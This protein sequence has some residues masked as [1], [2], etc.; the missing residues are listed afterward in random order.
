MEILTTHDPHGSLLAKKYV[1]G[2]KRPPGLGACAEWPAAT[3]E[4]GVFFFWSG[5]DSAFLSLSGDAWPGLSG[6]SIRRETKQTVPLSSYS[7]FPASTTH[8]RSARRF[9]PRPLLPVSLGSAAA[10]FGVR[11]GWFRRAPGE[12]TRDPA[13]ACL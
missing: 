4:P 9:R 3:Q 5:K 13:A 10:G 8:F 6:L 11:C 2:P 7:T 1:R 12:G